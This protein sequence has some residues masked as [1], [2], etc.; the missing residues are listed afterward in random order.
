MTARLGLQAAEALDHAH[1]H[2][3]IHRDVKPGNLLLDAAGRLWVADFGLARCGSEPGLTGTDHLVGT[4]RYMSPEQ[5]LARRALVDHRSDVYSLGATLYEALTLEPAYPAADRAELLRQIADGAPRPPRR[6]N[7]AVPAELETVVLKAMAPEPEARYATAQELA[8]DL[9]RFLEGRPVLAARP[10]LRTRAARWAR[11]HR[12]A[13]A[14]AAAAAA[15]ALAGLVAAVV[16]LLN[17]RGK[18]QAALAQAEVGR[19]R[20]EENFRKAL[21]GATDMLMQLDERPD[22]PPLQGEALRQA[23]V[24]QGLRF[25]RNFID[26]D[27]PDP[28]VRFESARAYGLM[29]TVYCSQ[30][31][32]EDGQAMLR[33]KF[34]L[35]EG[36][37]G[38]D[39]DNYA[40]RREQIRT[41]NLMGLMYTSL[42][43][44]REAR[45]E[46][47]RTAELHRQALPHDVGGA[48][49]SAY[50]WFLVDCPDVTLRDSARA[51]SLA[52]EAVLRDPGKATHWNVLGIARYQAGDWAAAVEALEKSMALD[53]GGDPWDWFYLAMAC[54]R[55]GDRDRARAWYARSIRWMEEHPPIDE[56]L[57]RYRK[58]ADALFG[59]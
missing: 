42:G 23:L 37:V 13:V 38:A 53:G 39:P 17:E 46:Y 51:V 21:E 7:P 24:E 8:D 45:E 9:R 55:Q 28:A 20:A 29:G 1:Q 26:E 5:A 2:G 52:G 33:K 57:I 35:L 30:H 4:L 47:A 25:F 16:L 59:E 27:N 11:R 31:K 44:P 18:K 3:V 41:R 15:L 49:L 6:V 58:E 48:A 40:Y 32:L 54:W 43:H 10:A 12:S 19:A 36:L 14:A 50:A 22:R 56:S 34:A